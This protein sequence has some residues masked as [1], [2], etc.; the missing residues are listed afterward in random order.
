M[1]IHDSWESMEE[2]LRGTTCSPSL[3]TETVSG[4]SPLQNYKKGQKAQHVRPLCQIL[5]IILGC[6]S[7]IWLAQSAAK[8]RRVVNG[9]RKQETLTP[10]CTPWAAVLLPFVKISRT[11]ELLTIS[12][13]LRNLLRDFL[14]TS[15]D[16]A[17][18]PK[19]LVFCSQLYYLWF[20]ARSK[21][22]LVPFRDSKLTRVFQGFFTGR[23]RSCMIV[24]VNPCASTYD[25]T[26][27]VAKFSAI[28]SQVRSQTCDGCAHLELVTL[29]KLL[30][31]TYGVK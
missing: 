29:R 3:G 11:G 25:E 22:N 19:G 4:P 30:G 26:L 5:C 10:L 23:G 12:P 1:A 13:G 17:R 21:Q 15:G 28:A 20:S 14:V 16:G 8:I 24:N 31:T 18:I 6:H 9:W 7:V 27:H 2:I